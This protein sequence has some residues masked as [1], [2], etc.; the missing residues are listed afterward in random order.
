M[1]NLLTNISLKS[2]KK[3]VNISILDEFRVDLIRFKCSLKL[4]CL[5]DLIVL[6]IFVPTM[7]KL[8]NVEVS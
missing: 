1:L 8:E 6:I 7:V 5:I 3:S 4:V 2:V